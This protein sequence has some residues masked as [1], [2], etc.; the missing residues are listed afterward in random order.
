MLALVFLSGHRS[1]RS[2]RQSRGLRKWR[3]CTEVS[4]RA[5]RQTAEPR[6]LGSQY[7]RYQHQHRQLETPFVLLLLL[8]CLQSPTRS[9]TATPVKQLSTRQLHRPAGKCLTL[10]P[11]YACL[12]ALRYPVMRASANTSCRATGGT[13]VDRKDAGLSKG[14]QPS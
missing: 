7:H 12:G 11:C 3:T 14:Y 10:L 13:W 2:A 9:G 6:H 4:G 8:L 1:H 5:G